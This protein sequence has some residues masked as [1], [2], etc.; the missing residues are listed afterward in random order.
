MVIKVIINNN[1]DIIVNDVSKYYFRCLKRDQ[2]YDR[3]G[4]YCFQIFKLIPKSLTWTFWFVKSD[5]VEGRDKC[6]AEGGGV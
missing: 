1:K 6:R 5:V 2:R 3:K 4:F